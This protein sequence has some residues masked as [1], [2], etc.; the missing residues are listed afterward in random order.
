MKKLVDRLMTKDEINNVKSFDDIMFRKSKYSTDK[1]TARTFNAEFE[2]GNRVSFIEDYEEGLWHNWNCR[3]SFYT[4]E[5]TNEYVDT[6]Q[7][8]GVIEFDVN[9][10]DELIRIF[11]LNRDY[12]HTEITK[13]IIKEN[14]NG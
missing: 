9:D 3:V 7:Y 2:N 14:S 5:E 1:F 6:R 10:T 12:T 13:H 4:D 8:G 11:L